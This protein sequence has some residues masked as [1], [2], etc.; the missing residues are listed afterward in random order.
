MTKPTNV[1]MLDF[2]DAQAMDEFIE[3]YERDASELYEG[4]ENLMLI[5]VDEASCV[6]ISVYADEDAQMRANE[7]SKKRRSE[8][9][10]IKEGLRLSG[11][12]VVHH[13]QN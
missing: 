10:W 7:V 1:V 13:K 11:D 12:L 9:T 2:Q 4:Y 8:I 5:R 6:A 3:M